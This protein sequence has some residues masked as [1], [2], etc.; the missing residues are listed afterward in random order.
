MTDRIYISVDQG[1]HGGLQ[2]SIGVE[3]A[4]GGG[5]GYRIF[6]PK[7]DGAGKRL[8]RHYLSARDADEIKSYLKKVA[9]PALPSQ[10]RS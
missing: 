5:H 2:L 8:A 9:A 1:S 6:G 4:D 10:E 3:N 7:Y